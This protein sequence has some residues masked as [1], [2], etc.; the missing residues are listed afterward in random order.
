M[1]FFKDYVLERVLSD[2]R[3]AKYFLLEMTMRGVKIDRPISS[4]SHQEAKD[5][6]MAIYEEL[7]RQEKNP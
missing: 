3:T 7:E 4:L 2:E 5:C 6:A 1:S